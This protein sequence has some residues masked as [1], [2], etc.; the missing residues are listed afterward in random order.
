MFPFLENTQFKAHE[1]PAGRIG[2]AMA[3]KDGNQLGTA[4]G[5]RERR[6][7]L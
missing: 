3:Q 5:E 2:Q 4:R 6:M 1:L 7:R